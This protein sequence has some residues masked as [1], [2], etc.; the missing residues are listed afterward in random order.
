[1]IQLNAHDETGVEF[2]Y[3]GPIKMSYIIQCLFTINT[4]R[5]KVL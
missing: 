4:E 5:I 2:P 3:R 1:M